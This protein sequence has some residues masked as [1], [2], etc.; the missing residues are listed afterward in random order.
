M[1]NSFFSDHVVLDVGDRA[2]DVSVEGWLVTQHEVPRS[3]TITDIKR[4]LIILL[5]FL[6]S[7]ALHE[8]HQRC[9]FRVQPSSLNI[10]GN[11]GIAT[12][13]F[14]SSLK[15]SFHLQTVASKPPSSPFSLTLLSLLENVFGAGIIRNRLRHT[16]KPRRTC[17]FREVAI[18]EALQSHCP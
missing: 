8:V 1:S 5:Q 3:V 17:V 16:S 4:Q 12:L 6:V 11:L 7:L 10:R 14:F 13:P 2:P 9:V 18:L 15:P